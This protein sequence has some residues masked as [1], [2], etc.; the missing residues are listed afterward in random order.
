MNIEIALASLSCTGSSGRSPLSYSAFMRGS[1]RRYVAKSFCICGRIIWAF[2]TSKEAEQGGACE[3]AGKHHDTRR[4]IFASGFNTPSPGVRDISRLSSVG[5]REESNLAR[6]PTKGSEHSYLQGARERWRVETRESSSARLFPSEV[7]Q[8]ARVAAFGPHA[9][10]RGMILSIPHPGC[11][12]RDDPT[13]SSAN[14]LYTTN[15]YR[16]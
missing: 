4:W 10:K 5:R 1:C 11:D 15:E 2:Q 12:G 16:A 8:E 13:V 7:Q 9:E 14:P 3:G 6:H